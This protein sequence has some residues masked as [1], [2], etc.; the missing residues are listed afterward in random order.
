MTYEAMKYDHLKGGA[1]KGFSDSQLDL[2]FTL[3][4]G[5]AFMDNIKWS[6]GSRRFGAVKDGERMRRNP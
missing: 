5:Y 6:D 4:Q 2:H 3:Y 1:L